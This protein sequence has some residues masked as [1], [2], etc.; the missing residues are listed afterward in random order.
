MG[1]FAR[2]SPRFPLQAFVWF[3]VSQQQQ[4]SVSH[5]VRQ[6]GSAIPTFRKNRT[7]SAPHKGLIDY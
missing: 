1:E 2:E 6:E 3:R 5:S 7:I 4:Q